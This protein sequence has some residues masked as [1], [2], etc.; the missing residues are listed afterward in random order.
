MSHM[1]SVPGG[2]EQE[3]LAEEKELAEGYRPEKGRKKIA[4]GE[5]RLAFFLVTPTVLLLA[6]IVG[7]P[8]VKAIIA[9]F[10]KDPGLNAATGFF[11]KGGQFA[12]FDN[13]KT[14]L[15]NQCPTA[16]GGTVKCP[17]GT[18]ASEFW[19]SVGFTLGV[20]IV[21]VA[22]ET[23][24]GMIMALMMHKAFK[25]RG[26]IRAAILIPWA[27]PTAVSAKLWQVIYAPGGVANKLFGEGITWSE[28]WPARIAIVFTDTWKTTPFM[29]L[30]IL[31]GLQG[32]PDE[33]YESAKVDG[34]S[35]WQRFWRITLPLVKPALAVALIF[36]SLDTL[37]MYDLP[38]ILTGGANGTST[39]SILVVK[40]IQSGPNAASALSTITFVFIFA[41]AFVLVKLLGASIFPK[42]PAKVKAR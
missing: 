39:L 18:L 14:W 5:G 12:G 19:P 28:K 3:A 38:A 42:P 20:T 13:Y 16:S 34:A 4:T 30:L 36:R 31:A 23:V 7:Y 41:C 35:A 21:A 24:L 11:N 25:G 22:L 26:I 27:I 15:L 17:P 8:I 32:I 2:V 37:R 9:S 40:Q 29:A 10:Q 6:L 1:Q 33:L